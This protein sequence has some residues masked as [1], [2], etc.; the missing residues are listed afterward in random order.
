MKIRFVG[1]WLLTTVLL[2][3][4][5]DALVGGAC[6]EGYEERDG[7]CELIGH[8]APCEGFEHLGA[9]G[10]G[11][12]SDIVALDG[13]ETGDGGAGG[14]GGEGSVPG[15]DAGAPVPE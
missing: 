7:A 1:R 15:D 5:G 12:E 10:G 2:T 8:I 6:A 3:G 9:G 13:A 11:G 14:E 4:C